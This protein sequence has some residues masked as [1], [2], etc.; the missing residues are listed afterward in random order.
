M[1]LLA[2]WIQ[3]YHLSD[4]VLWK[5]IV[6]Y[7]YMINRP[8]IFCCLDNG[9]SPFWKGV[10]WA[11]QAARNGYCWNIGNGRRVRF[12]EDQWFGS[13]SLAVQYWPLYIICNEKRITVER[14]WDDAN[15]RLTFRRAVSES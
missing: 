4:Y 9:T 5:D 14:V 1:C 15:L 13:S 8:N 2:S 11:A 10:L 12:W 7:K 3:R 6:D